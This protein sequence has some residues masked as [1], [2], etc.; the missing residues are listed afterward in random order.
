[1]L[2]KVLSALTA[3]GTLGFLLV[4]LLA[5]VGSMPYGDEP[6][7]STL[8]VVL[9]LSLVFIA[10]G[11]LSMIA[12]LN[13]SHLPSDAEKAEW[14]RFLSVGGPIAAAGYLWAVAGRRISSTDVAE[15]HIKK[16]AAGHGD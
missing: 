1:M 3:F 5:F 15:S 4:F 9:T 14:R 16:N 13:L 12:H 7:G 2:Y 10:V 11:L 8:Q 6:G